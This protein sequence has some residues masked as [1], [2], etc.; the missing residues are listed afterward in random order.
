MQ[1]LFDLNFTLSRGSIVG[2]LGENGA[3]KSTMMNVIGGVLKPDSGSMELDGDEYLPVS[4][5]D[6][7]KQKIV[8]IHQEL[9]LLSNLTVAENF[10]IDEFP[11]FGFI[12]LINK[13]RM[14]REC[15]ELLDSLGVEVRSTDLVEELSPGSRQMVEIAKALRIDADL[16]LF[17]EPTTSL[18]AKETAILFK[19]IR[20]LKEKNKTVIYISHILSDVKNLTDYILVLRDG[21]LV[22]QGKT[23][24]YTTDSMV[25]DMIGK[26]MSQIFPLM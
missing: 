6:A 19:L 10:M 21:H 5:S 8:F 7:K 17:D 11:S 14:Y 23:V 9:N 13:R 18:T 16:Y 4:P 3:G 1:V 12:P 26:E 2:L 15:Q 22:A 24:D 20:D 25:T